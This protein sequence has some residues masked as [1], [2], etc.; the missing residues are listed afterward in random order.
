MVSTYTWRG[1]HLY[2]VLCSCQ[3][4]VNMTATGVQN[5]EIKK[6]ECDLQQSLQEIEKRQQEIEKL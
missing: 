3:L 4:S 5:N 6:L 2:T 1:E